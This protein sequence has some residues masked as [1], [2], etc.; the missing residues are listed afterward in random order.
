VITC[1]SWI[2]LMMIRFN[3][4]WTGTRGLAFATRESMRDPG[5]IIGPAAKSR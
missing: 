1:C 4:I 5:S 2:S 3:S